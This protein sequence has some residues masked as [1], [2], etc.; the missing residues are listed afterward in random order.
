[1]KIL[2]T[3]SRTINLRE[4]VFYILDKEISDGDFLIQGGANG[5]DNLVIEW[6]NS[7]KKDVNWNTIRPLDKTDK[8][9]YLLRNVEM[10]TMCDKVIAIW[11][12][13]SKGTK[14]TINYAKARNKPVKI[15]NQ[16]VLEEQSSGDKK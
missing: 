14:F 2:I 5:V 13:K 11:D 16:E 10:I 6:C 15:Y 4:Y 1:M 7:H 3:G 8:F 12:G 9:S